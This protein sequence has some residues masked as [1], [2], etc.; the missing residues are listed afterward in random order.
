MLQRLCPTP[1]NVSDWA[2][3][4]MSQIDWVVLDTETTG[5]PGEII[6]LAIINHEGEVVFDSLLKPTISIPPEATKIHGITD[7]DVQNAHSFATLWPIIQIKLLG[8]RIIT[9]N[10]EFDR[11]AFIFTS[12]RHHVELHDMDWECLMKAYAKYRNEPNQYGSPKWHK[13]H[14]ACYQQ[15]FEIIQAHRALGD[16]WAAYELMKRIAKYDQAASM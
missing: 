4:N 9:Y 13:L 3:V 11:N 14:E 1:Q 15:G 7:N 12:K 6:D 8:K 10:A 2:W 5:R 16:A